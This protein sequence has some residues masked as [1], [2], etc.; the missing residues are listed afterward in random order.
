MK[1]MRLSVVAAVAA[2]AL[3]ASACQFGNPEPAVRNAPAGS[4][5]R[6]LL[7]IGDSLLGQQDLALPGVLASR[8][9]DTTVIDAHVNGT[10]LIGPVGSA[11][12]AM[13]WVQQQVAAH[14]EADPVV[15]QWVGVCALCGTTVDGTTYP[16]IGSAEFYSSWVA[17]AFAVIDWLHGQGKTVVWVTSPPVGR[18]PDS[19][20]A[21]VDA[22]QLLSM[23]DTA[24]IGPHTGQRTLD[25]YTALSDT[26]RQ[27]ATTLWYHDRLHDVRFPDLL[28]IT[29]EGA[30]R[31][32]I[33]SADGLVDVFASMPAPAAA[34]AGQP[35]G[36]VQAGDPVGR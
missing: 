15:L 16:A 28:H 36:L 17:N 10:G 26:N 30:T 25:W 19:I 31:A 24:V 27:Y 33:W 13:A 9:F 32:A 8:G 12:S 7:M 5:H 23:Y 22:A 18:A 4:P 35:S 11:P 1:R 2:V 14:P 6:T 21:R 29:L 3:L 20:P 34:T